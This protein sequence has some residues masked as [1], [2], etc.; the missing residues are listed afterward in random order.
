MSVR[1]Q[2]WHRTNTFAHSAFGV[3]RL[4]HE[5][6]STVSVCLPARNEA[7][8]IGAILDELMPLVRRGVIDQIAV[9]D[10]STDDTS[11][12]ARSFG[13]E[14]YDQERLS[15]EFGPVLGK[16]DAIWRA[17]SVLTGDVVVYLDA[18]SERFGPH[19]ALG[20]AGP[21]V[22]GGGIDFVKGCYRRPFK[23]GDT[24]SAAGG[25]RVTELT[26]RPL[27]NL[28]YPQLAG[29]RQPLAGEIG[30]RRE[31][32][33]RLPFATGY[34]V[35]IGM[36]IDAWATVGIWSMAQVDLDV[37]QNRHQALSDLGPM[38][39]AV[40]RGVTDRLRREGRMDGF[41]PG[42]FLMTSASGIEARALE[43]VERPPMS[44][45]RAAV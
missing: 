39:Y 34:A 21:I 35:E 30:A 25:G 19:F 37:R 24:A 32:F 42:D 23:L 22:C 6:R 41:E 3:E 12:I 33:E 17:L 1:A 27:L 16:G 45:L 28:F 43:I 8:T 29:F 44:S 36:L 15:P 10:H 40:L 31:L 13:V 5:K 11:E 38:A 7:A 9:V 2:T 26:A 18:D 20:I 4:T 14:V